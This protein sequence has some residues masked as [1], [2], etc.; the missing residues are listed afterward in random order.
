[1]VRIKRAF[2]AA[3]FLPQYGRLTFIDAWDAYEWC[4]EGGWISGRFWEGQIGASSWGAY[5]NAKV[6]FRVVLDLEG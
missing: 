5:K 2:L 1:L 4:Q 6:T 3:K